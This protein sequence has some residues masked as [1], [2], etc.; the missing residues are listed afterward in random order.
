MSTSFEFS[1]GIS[2]SSK[3]SLSTSTER[4][5]ENHQRLPLKNSKFSF[6]PLFRSLGASDSKGVVSRGNRTWRPSDNNFFPLLAKRRQKIGNPGGSRHPSS[7]LT[8][9]ARRPPSFYHPSASCHPRRG[10]P[11]QSLDVQEELSRGTKSP[12]PARTK[13]YRREDNLYARGM[14]ALSRLHPTPPPPPPPPQFSTFVSPF[15]AFIPV[16]LDPT[17]PLQPFMILSLK[18]WQKVHYKCLLENLVL[19]T[20]LCKS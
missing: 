6:I 7:L 19:S 16:R 11:S 14:R 3:F 8:T 9:P 2:T 10:V 20:F 13:Q 1:L 17:L 15:Y 18:S 4:S 12:H 5:E